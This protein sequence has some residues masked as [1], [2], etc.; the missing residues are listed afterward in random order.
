MNGRAAPRAG[1]VKGA[2]HQ[3]LAGAGFAG[4]EHRRRLVQRGNLPDLLHHRRQRRGAP[5]DPGE[6]HLAGRPASIVGELLLHQRGFAGPVGQQLQLLQIH[7]LLHVVE[8]AELDRLDRAL[9]GAVRGHDDD[10]D[11]GI[12][13]ADPSE[14]LDAAHAGKAHIGE[15]HIGPEAL[16]QLLGP[17]SIAGDLRL[18]PCLRQEGLDRARERALIVDDEHGRPTHDDAPT[19]AGPRPAAAPA[20]WSRRAGW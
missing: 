17:F 4:D 10:R 19:A 5:Q 3:S 7:R 14:Q 16:D 20:R 1:C 15:H 9:D 8:G 12:E 2:G 13:L 11:G 6:G 18:V